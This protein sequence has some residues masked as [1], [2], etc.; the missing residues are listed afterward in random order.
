MLQSH[1]IKFSSDTDTE[2][3]AQ[4]IGHFYQGDIVS[5]TQQALSLMQ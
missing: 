4:L 5:A 1:N 2:V 3:V